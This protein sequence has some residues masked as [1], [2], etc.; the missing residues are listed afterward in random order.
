MFI[1][2]SGCRY[3]GNI[4]VNIMWSEQKR[5]VE[6]QMRLG[7]GIGAWQLSLVRENLNSVFI[8]RGLYF[9]RKLRGLFQGK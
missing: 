7:R 5:L 2:A 4:Q 1:G 8:G 9:R 3:V 6:T